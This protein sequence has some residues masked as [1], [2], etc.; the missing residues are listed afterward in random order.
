MLTRA[1][2]MLTRGWLTWLLGTCSQPAETLRCL[3]GELARLHPALTVLLLYISSQAAASQCF[4]LVSVS[5]LPT[6]RSKTN[7]CW[8][9][10]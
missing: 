1:V 2:G 8:R 10:R 7:H 5:S 6:P 4:D 9:M 3:G